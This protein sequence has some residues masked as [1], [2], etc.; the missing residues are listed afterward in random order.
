MLT[1][2]WAILWAVSLRAVQD[3]DERT[4]EIYV[5]ASYTA[6]EPAPLLLVLHGAGGTGARSQGWLGLDALAEE[7]GFIVVYPDGIAHNWDVGTG[8][9]TADGPIR[10][11]DVAF[12]VWLVDH[13]GTRYTLDRTRVYVTGMS[14]GALMAYKLACAAPDTFAAVA[15]VAAPLYVPVIR[16][17]SETPMSI[18]MIH[19]TDDRILPWNRV[20]LNNGQLFGLSAIDSFSFWAQRN[21]CNQD[22][23]A[24]TGET[25]PDVDPD[26]QSTVRRIML[27]DC[28]ANTQVVLYGIEGGGHTWPG[29]PFDV[30]IELGAL[31]RDIDASVIIMDWLVNLPLRQQTEATPEVS[32]S[33]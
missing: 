30:D 17:C 31:N 22:P 33:P 8:I 27:S 25:L 29:R 15:G 21:G 6:Q 20:Q 16:D 4:Y 3:F 2:I 28:E 18:L 32:V 1:I 14:N 13:I 5:P 11:D 12:L 9:P 26:D 23:A 7:S 19:G 10:S 24:I